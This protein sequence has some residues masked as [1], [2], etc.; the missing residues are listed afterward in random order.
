M[1]GK[2][3]SWAKI[4]E[5]L[6]QTQFKQFFSC[7]NYDQVFFFLP[8]TVTG[9]PSSFSLHEPRARHLQPIL[10]QTPFKQ[11]VDLHYGLSDFVSSFSITFGAC[12]LL[13]PA[14]KNV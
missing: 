8:Y 6:I 11:S 2:E 1:S 10:S 5:Y 4:D 14:F 13:T 7:L 9:V 12:R 3:N